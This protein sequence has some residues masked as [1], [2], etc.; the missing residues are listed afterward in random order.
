MGVPNRTCKHCG[1]L[2]PETQG[3]RPDIAKPRPFFCDA[4]ACQEACELYAAAG[5]VRPSLAEKIIAL[6]PPPE[7]RAQLQATG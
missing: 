2:C 4:L 3:S 7:T 6:A 1:R 5:R